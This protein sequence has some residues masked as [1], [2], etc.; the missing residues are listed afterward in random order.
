[1]KKIPEYAVYAIEKLNNAGY[2]GYLVGGCVRDLIMGNAPHD[3]DITTN[4]LPEQTKQI[5]DGFTVIPTGEK[6][7]T[8]TVLI[9]GVPLEITTYRIDES[10]SDNRRPD[11]VTFTSCLENDLKRRD[12]TMNAMA[13]DVNG[14]ITDLFG[15]KEDIEKR[16]IKCVGD[17]EKRF[18]EDALRILRAL[19]FSSGLGFSID[20]STSDAI[21]KQKCLLK[22]ISAER[23]NA[24]F[25]G[26]VCGKNAENVLR[27][28]RDVI[29]VFIPEILPC[30]DF[31][32]HTRYH[33]YDVWEHIIHA[34]GSSVNREKVR[35]ALFFHD[36]AK[37][38][39]YKPD[40]KGVGHFKGHPL[41]SAEKTHNIMT[42]LR[43][44]KRF[45]RDV[46]AL[47]S[48]HSDELNSR[49][50]LRRLIGEIG[51]EN[52]LDLL[53]VQRADTLAKNDFC[54]ERLQKSDNQEKTVRE[55]IENHECT[56]LKD[57]AV[58]GNDLIMLGFSGIQ[59]RETLERILEAV[60]SDKI[61][62]Q[63]SVL[64][65]YAKLLKPRQ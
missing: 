14:K 43:F 48:H 17:A 26:I 2:E 39:C 42:R 19:R 8:V 18:E 62:N 56:S 58:N 38:E 30:F 64:I 29:A 9:E 60:F 27:S 49:S 1:M 36:I 44:S 65:D 40:E 7:G 3:F 33:K 16:I 53:D 22:N 13:M 20:E 35:I 31:Q 55:I 11:K 10:Y 54:R 50:E 21:H 45:V 46:T 57:L 4:A 41:A 28:Y 23:L 6:H 34:V 51:A 25:K 24:E 15:G 47:I 61:E 63:H 37:P 59:I 5:F 32:Q 12:F 52:V